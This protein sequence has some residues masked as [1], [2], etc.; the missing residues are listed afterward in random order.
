MDFH[1][2]LTQELDAAIQK[3]SAEDVDDPVKLLISPTPS[4][5]KTPRMISAP[6]NP[7]E[8]DFV[9]VREGT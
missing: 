6:N 2:F 3:K 9:L 5:M 8:E 7:P 4:R 1:F